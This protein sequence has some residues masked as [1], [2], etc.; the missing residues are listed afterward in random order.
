MG[1]SEEQVS[2]T[3]FGTT[4]LPKSSNADSL[5]TE[6]EQ[7]AILPLITSTICRDIWHQDC[8]ETEMTDGEN[9]EGKGMFHTAN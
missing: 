9:F 2:S 3:R 1:G 5:A 6:K 8:N 4:S 7:A